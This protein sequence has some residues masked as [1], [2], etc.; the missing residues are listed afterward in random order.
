MER[1]YL[2]HTV[3][4][5]AAV[6]RLWGKQNQGGQA[7]ERV[8]GEE[9]QVRERGLCVVSRCCDQGIQNCMCMYHSGEVLEPLEASILRDVS[10]T[11]WVES[12]GD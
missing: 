8:A 10:G 4:S 9:R 11:R 1:A 7:R 12:E 2:G 6:I 3:F 5:Q